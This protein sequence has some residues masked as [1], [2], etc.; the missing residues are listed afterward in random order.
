M[1]DD[2]QEQRDEGDPTLVRKG[3]STRARGRPRTEAPTPAALRERERRRLQKAGIVTVRVDLE[4][5]TI[6]SLVEAG[7]V[8][9]WHLERPRSR[10][11][12]L[13]RRE[14]I[15]AALLQLLMEWTEYVQVHESDPVRSASLE[16]ESRRLK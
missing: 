5:L 9:A 3:G 4:F 1:S 7:R 11:M 14:N 2:K 12:A 13:A 10:E 15:A 8:G 16:T 6:D